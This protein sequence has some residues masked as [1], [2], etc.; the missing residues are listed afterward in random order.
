[1][2]NLKKIAS[3]ADVATVFS[4]NGFETVDLSAVKAMVFIDA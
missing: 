4:T 3:T 1:V 2:L